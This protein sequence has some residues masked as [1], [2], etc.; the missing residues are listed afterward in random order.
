[1]AALINIFCLGLVGRSRTVSSCVRS[2]SP[3][4]T[5][6][7]AAAT[8]SSQVGIERVEGIREF[9]GGMS[10]GDCG[11]DGTN[12]RLL[13]TEVTVDPGGRVAVVASSLARAWS[14]VSGSGHRAATRSSRWTPL[15]H[16]PTG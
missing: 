3:S 10:V 12:D 16:R 11:D 4:R 8:G 7:S 9:G 6:R 1:V 15:L 2:R 5:Q 14:V 13:C